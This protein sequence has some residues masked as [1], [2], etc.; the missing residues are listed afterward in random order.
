M[1]NINW[2][3]ES[4][5]SLSI[6]IPLTFRAVFTNR[7][8]I[9][10]AVA[11]FSSFWVV[12]NVFDQLLFFSPMLTFYLP[13]DAIS[14]FILTNLTSVLMGVLVAMNVYAIRSQSSS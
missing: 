6:T 3:R 14:G 5:E 11:I 2:K 8:Y 4:I 12:F 7:L 10:I 9:A 13:D 1:F